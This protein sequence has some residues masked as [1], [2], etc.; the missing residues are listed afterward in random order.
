MFLNAKIVENRNI[1]LLYVTCINPNIS[2]AMAP[3]SQNTIE[4]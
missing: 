1:Q 2:S 3:I 4:R